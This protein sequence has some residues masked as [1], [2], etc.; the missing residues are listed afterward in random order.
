MRLRI[1]ASEPA[2]QYP[3]IAVLLKQ[4]RVFFVAGQHVEHITKLR[5]HQESGGR[6]MRAVPRFAVAWR[7]ITRLAFH[8]YCCASLPF[9]SEWI[10]WTRFEGSGRELS[11]RRVYDASGPRSA[12]RYVS[13]IVRLR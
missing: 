3:L 5:I 9:R 6:I 10:G 7:H 12:A 11:V 8:C 4:P 2:L 13:Q 1:S